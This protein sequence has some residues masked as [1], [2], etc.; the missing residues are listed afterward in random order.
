MICWHGRV[1]LFTYIP[2]IFLLQLNDVN[3]H[4]RL[5]LLLFSNFTS[6]KL[7]FKCYAMS[8]LVLHNIVSHLVSFLY[9]HSHLIILYLS[10]VWSYVIYRVYIC[11]HSFRSL[12]MHREGDCKFSCH[13]MWIGLEWEFDFLFFTRRPGK[14]VFK[15]S[16][17][18]AILSV[19]WLNIR[20]KMEI[21]VVYGDL[22]L[23]LSLISN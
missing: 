20:K 19:R 15:F 6:I 23:S 12:N 8:T 18:L 5:D 9:S 3:R 2:S 11:A 16:T 7:R 21:K 17:G 14:S 1:L 22:L 13:V 10:Q 4:L